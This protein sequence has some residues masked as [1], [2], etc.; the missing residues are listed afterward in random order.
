LRLKNYFILL[1]FIPSAW[2]ELDITSQAFQA[3]L[4]KILNL[5]T[6]RLRGNESS[7]DV[8]LIEE[9]KSQTSLNNCLAGSI[10]G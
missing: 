1:F 2:A 8:D 3:D 6:C 9:L 4:N 5:K 7:R 10:N